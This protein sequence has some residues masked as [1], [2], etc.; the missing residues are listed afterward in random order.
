MFVA[1][2]YRVI[3]PPATEPVTLALARQHCRIDSDHDDALLAMYLTGARLEAEAYL[4]RALFTQRLRYSVTWAPAPA[5]VPL[6][7]PIVL[8]LAW[9][10]LIRRP[11]ELPRAAPG[12]SVDQVM[13]GPLDDLTLAD[14]ADYQV[15]LD[16]EPAYIAILPQMV[17]R[18]NPQQSVVVEYTA[19]YDDADPDMVPMPIRNALLVGAAHYYENRGDVPA[20]MPKAFYRLLD[21]YRLWTFAG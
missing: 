17:S 4:N 15:N 1:A 13:W 3:V 7:P 14:P 16:A 5:T 21:P 19:G 20:E 9:P 11:L 6:V 18:L 8:P 2:G 10:P 12:Q